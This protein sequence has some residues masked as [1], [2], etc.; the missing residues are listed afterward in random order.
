MKIIVLFGMGNL[1]N[2]LVPQIVLLLGKTNIFSLTMMKQ[3]GVLRSMV[4]NVSIAKN[5]V[6]QKK[7][8][9]FD[10]YTT[11]RTNLRKSCQTR[12]Q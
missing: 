8:A 1:A 12:F 2:D 4:S 3:N 9:D 11:S 10:H 7:Y 5:F 6:S